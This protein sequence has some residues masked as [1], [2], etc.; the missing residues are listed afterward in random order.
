MATYKQRFG[1]SQIA[2]TIV[3]GTALNGVQ[4]QGR[5]SGVAIPSGQIGQVTDKSGSS[6]SIGAGT[7]T[8]AVYTTTI[9]A[10]MYLVVGN[11]LLTW[12]ATPGISNFPLVTISGDVFTTESSR[13]PQKPAS[14]NATDSFAVMGYFTSTGSNT[15]TVN[16]TN[17]SSAASVTYTTVLKFIRIA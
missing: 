12:S 1:A 16:G 8:T 14:A 13:I 3:E 5:T 17:F 6:S 15:F 4:I 11:I 10:G 7:N 9:A 2:D